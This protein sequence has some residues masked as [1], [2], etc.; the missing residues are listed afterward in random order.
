M[1]TPQWSGTGEPLHWSFIPRGWH[2]AQL[3]SERRQTFHPSSSASTT[4][5]VPPSPH[6]WPLRTDWP[7]SILQAQKVTP[8]LRWAQ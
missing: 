4:P 3:R 5:P 6:F 2:H 1:T 8:I 7:E